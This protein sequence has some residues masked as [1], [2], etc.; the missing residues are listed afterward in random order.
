MILAERRVQRVV[1]RRSILLAIGRYAML[2]NWPDVSLV[3]REPVIE[4]QLGRQSRLSCTGA[5]CRG[6][7]AV[8]GLREFI[9]FEWNSCIYHTK[10]GINDNYSH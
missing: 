6:L 7:G 3:P 4:S 5:M 2:D 8:S 10:C 9:N 1:Y